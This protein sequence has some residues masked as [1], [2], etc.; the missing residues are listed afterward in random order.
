MFLSQSLLHSVFLAPF[1]NFQCNTTLEAADNS[2]L[3]LAFRTLARLQRVSK[4]FCSIINDCYSQILNIEGFFLRESLHESQIQV[5]PFHYD[6]WSFSIKKT[7]TSLDTVN[8]ATGL[9]QFCDGKPFVVVGLHLDL[10][11]EDL[12]RFNKLS[13][14][15]NSIH[16]VLA[17]LS[18]FSFPSLIIMRICTDDGECNLPLEIPATFSTI[19]T[20]QVVFYDECSIP[21]LDVSHLRNL[22]SLDVIGGFDPYLTL[23]G[24]N[25]LEQLSNTSFH[26]IETFDSFHP[27]ARIQ[28]IV[29]DSCRIDFVDKVLQQRNVLEHCLF[30]FTEYSEHFDLYFIERHFWIL[31]HV[32]S[33]KF[34]EVLFPSYLMPL[35]EVINIELESSEWSPKSAILNLDKVPRLKKISGYFERIFISFTA[36]KFTS[37]RELHIKSFSSSKNQL[38]QLFEYS[39]LLRIIDSCG[40]SFNK[41]SQEQALK[42]IPCSLNHLNHLFIKSIWSVLPTCLR[43]KTLVVS[44]TKFAF[45]EFYNKFPNLFTLVL[46]HVEILADKMTPHHGVQDLTMKN[47]MFT[48]VPQFLS[49]FPSLIVLKLT[50]KESP[51]L[52]HLPSCLEYLEYD[53]P[54]DA[55]N[56]SLLES[57]SLIVIKRIVKE[58]TRR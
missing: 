27:N 2:D 43:L 57:R 12:G 7:S 53:G 21:S 38:D 22:T 26:N 56:E 50:L 42:F 19:S 23:S 48:H 40:W 4:R 24:I 52:I 36:S 39:P 54:Q 34:T 44:R 32:T 9:D 1:L 55:V 14:K 15:S 37:I 46:E 16:L 6:S 58:T 29:V 8:L 49:Y 35:L 11:N 18:Q 45:D 31:D 51:S 17:N 30:K 13:F 3:M 47:C 28:Q 20:L 33:F 25:S 41:P 10:N 5:L